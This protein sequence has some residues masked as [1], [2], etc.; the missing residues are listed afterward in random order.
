QQDLLRFCDG[1]PHTILLTFDQES[2]FTHLELQVN[3]SLDMYLFDLPKTTQSN[4]RS[5]L[6]NMQDMTI[7]MSPK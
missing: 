3:Q 4:V 1:R 5:Q 7:L 6:Q 2:D